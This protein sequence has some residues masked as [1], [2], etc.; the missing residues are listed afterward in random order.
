MILETL[1]KKMKKTG[2]GKLPSY[3]KVLE[4][5]SKII[6]TGE[7]CGITVTAYE[8]GFITCVNEYGDA[9]VFTETVKITTDDLDTT[10]IS[11][12]D[13][14]KELDAI[15]ILSSIGCSR[16]EH[17]R[18]VRTQ[19]KEQKIYDEERELEISVCDTYSF[20]KKYDEQ[21]KEKTK[22]K[23]KYLFD[24]LTDAQKEVAELLVQGYKIK[25]IVEELHIS[26]SSVNNRIEGIENKIKK[27][28][29]KNIYFGNGGWCRIK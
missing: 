29:Q 18:S 4:M 12:S 28:F 20:E 11:L 25:Q 6:L 13:L 19:R 9:T 17:N 16:I 23:F 8:N 14:D 7:C 1:L 24:S 27:K 10:I 22:K 2:G 15:L 3:K 21:E 26:R 5:N